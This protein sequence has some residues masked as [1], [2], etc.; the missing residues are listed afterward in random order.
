[1]KRRLA[2]LATALAALGA[3]NQFGGTPVDMAN[4]PHTKA[5]LWVEAGTLH[6]QTRAPFQFCDPG[7]AIFPPKDAACSQWQAVRTPDGAIDFHAVCADAGA[8]IRL[9]RHIA[10]DLAS[11]FTDD[12]TSTMDAPKNTLS[13]H[14]ALRYV[15]PCPPGMKTFNP[16]AG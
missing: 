7:R 11:A 1:M 15:G 12:I 9:H 10:G 14:A 13:A 4:P 5:G 2:A 16:T 6:G 3:C 8:T